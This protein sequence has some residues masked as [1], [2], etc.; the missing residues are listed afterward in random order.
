METARLVIALTLVG[1]L[2]IFTLQ[3][4]ESI[5]V[6]VLFWDFEASGAIFVFMLVAAG[7]LVGWVLRSFREPGGFNLFG[8]G[9]RE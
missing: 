9:H 1:L 7:I 3:N 5:G 6:K 4:T 2:I 8:R